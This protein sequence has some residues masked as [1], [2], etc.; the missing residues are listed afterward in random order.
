MK[1][2]IKEYERISTLYLYGG[3]DDEVTEKFIE[4]MGETED[5]QL[6]TASIIAQYSNDIDWSDVKYIMSVNIYNEYIKAFDR[7]QEIY[8]Q[9]TDIAAEHG[10]NVEELCDY[11][12]E[13][14][15]ITKKDC[16]AFFCI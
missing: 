13:K 16:K 1:V 9:I 3:G 14:G 7:V 8:D 2:F 10:M 5:C 4:N 15:I 12:I 6:V 11:M